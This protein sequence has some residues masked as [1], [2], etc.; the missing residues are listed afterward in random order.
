[1]IGEFAY[2]LGCERV[3]AMALTSKLKGSMVLVIVTLVVLITSITYYYGNTVRGIDSFSNGL[4]NFS[5][6]DAGDCKS[7]DI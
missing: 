5:F 3:V 6:L 7:E 4:L 2:Q 1:M